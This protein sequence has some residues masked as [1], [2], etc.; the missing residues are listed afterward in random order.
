M[1]GDAVASSD[2]ALEATV[3]LVYVLAT[4][5]CFALTFVLVRGRELLRKR[6]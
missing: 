6:S 2:L 3:E 1:S 5:A 4:I